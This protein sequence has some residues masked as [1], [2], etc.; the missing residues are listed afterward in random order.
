MTLPRGPAAVS[1]SELVS[2]PEEVDAVCR[3]LR[4]FL[5]T[6]AHAADSFAVELLA[7][8]ALNNALLHGH[9]AQADKQARLSLRLGRRWL[10]LQITDAGAG[11]NWRAARLR[12]AAPTDISGRGLAISALYADR[13]SY[14]QRG[15]QITLWLDNRN[16]AKRHQHGKLHA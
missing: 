12:E 10:R 6:N 3:Q 13:V 8:E 2:R 5:Q 14:N 1:L 11:F 9:Q 15:N 7:R 16:T 4:S